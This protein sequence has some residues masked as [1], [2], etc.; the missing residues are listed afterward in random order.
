MHRSALFIC[1][2]CAAP[3]WPDDDSV[4]S[5][6]ADCYSDWI[7]ELYREFDDKYRIAK[8]KIAKKAAGAK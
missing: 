1:P 5:F 6:H 8:V 4:D 7:T 2:G 3:V